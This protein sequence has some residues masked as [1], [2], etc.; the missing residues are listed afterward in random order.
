[1]WPRNTWIARRWGQTQRCVDRVG[2]ISSA[3]RSHL[4]PWRWRRRWAAALAGHNRAF[5]SPPCSWPWCAAIC[6]R[7]REEVTGT[8]SNWRTEEHGPVGRIPCIRA[9]KQVSNTLTLSWEQLT[10][11]LMLLLPSFLDEDSKAILLC[12]MYCELIWKMMNSCFVSQ[13]SIEDTDVVS[14]Y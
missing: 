3:Y 14:L 4:F 13:N 10:S 2:C 6:G 1:M 7:I 11:A 9:V 5:C 12:K 8:S